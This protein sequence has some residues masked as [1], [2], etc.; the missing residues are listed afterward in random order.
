MDL[1]EEVS[2]FVIGF[3]VVEDVISISGDWFGWNLVA[4]YALR[5]VRDIESRKI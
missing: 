4:A 1:G 2:V 5:V 3:A